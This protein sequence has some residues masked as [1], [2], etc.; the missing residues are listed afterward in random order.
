MVKKRKEMEKVL[1]KD[2]I[3]SNFRTLIPLEYRPTC[4]L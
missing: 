1:P 2:G 3:F 4:L